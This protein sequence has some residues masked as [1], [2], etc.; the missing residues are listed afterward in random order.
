[1]SLLPVVIYS[2]CL[3][4][5]LGCT[6]LLLRGYRKSG[7]RLLLWAG[8]CFA[9]LSLNNLAVLLDMMV[10]VE[11]DLQGW[12]HAASLIAV[13]TLIVGLVWEAD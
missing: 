9:F 3:A 2:L 8:I 13:T 7:T 4:S 5:C 1:M 11:Q 12:R 10:M 6:F